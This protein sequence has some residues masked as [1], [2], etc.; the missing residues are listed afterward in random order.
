MNGGSMLPTSLKHSIGFATML[1]AW[2]LV[3][4]AAIAVLL[5]VYGVVR[6]A[7]GSL[8]RLAAA[9]VVIGWL[10]G[11]QLITA[12][13]RPLKQTA[14]LMVDQSPSMALRGRDALARAITNQIEA[15]TAGRP[16]LDLRVVTVHPS[17]ES[18]SAHGTRLFD[19][20]SQAAADIPPDRLAGAI[21]LSDGQVHDVPTGIPQALQPTGQSRPVPLD[22]ILTGRGEE[23]DRRLR[24][25]SAP[26]Y[27]IVGQDAVIRVQIDDL[28][29]GASPDATA[30][31]TLTLGGASAEHRKIRVGQPQDITLPVMRPGPLLVG[32]SASELPGEVSTSN[33]ADIITINGVRD[34]LKVLLVSGTPNQGERVW[35][36]LLKADPS[37]DLVHFTILRPPDK[38]DGTPLSDMALIAFPVAELF[39]EKIGQFD[40]IILDGFQNRAILPPAYLRNIANYVRGGGGLL[41]IG[42]PEFVGPGTLQDTPVGDILPAHVPEEG[43][44]IEQAFRPELS[45][46][47]RRHPVTADLPGATN[48]KDGQ[49]TWGPW[50]RALKPDSTVGE[51]LMTGPDGNPLLLLNHVDQGRV[52]LLL[53]D[54]IWLW[55]HGENG[56]GP[57]SEL[58]RRLSHWLMKEPELEEEQL[59]ASITGDELR[60]VRRSVSDAP[61]PP[62]TVTA[63][64]GRKTPLTLTSN[65]PGT[66]SAQ[67]PASQPGL[68]EVTDGALHAYAGPRV[69]DPLE[70]SD[71]R[72]SA[73]PLSDIVK[74]T[75]GAVYW[76]GDPA[77]APALRLVSSGAATKGSDWIGLTQRN[78]H[79]VTGESARPLCPGWLALLLT[80]LLLAAG[81]WREG[82]L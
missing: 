79:S 60:V 4:L 14:L 5:G 67:M 56:G 6:R 39:Q 13:W 9:L 48:G 45:P 64:D 12:T 78:A 7:S 23:T 50:Y 57:Q 53:S 30:D 24:I 75:G 77:H 31:L 51:T 28:G 47:G 10:A 65:G 20:L 73:Q 63:P 80:A 42:G 61:P 36:R 41:L 33:N 76:S 72:A 26:P 69:A 1:P 66:A 15:A 25:L 38:D 49:S 54:Q 62:V 8:A 68:W 43:G 52:A 58:L 2:L 16:D 71:L 44:L 82:R 17:S 32:L 11:P 34:R 74:K 18:G 29:P 46:I 55:S 21:M 3:A 81:W 70:F 37:V 27:A 35:R 59:T 19:A 22:V 40:L